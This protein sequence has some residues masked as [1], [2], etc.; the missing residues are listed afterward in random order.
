MEIYERKEESIFAKNVT[1]IKI[2]AH[3]IHDLCRLFPILEND[4]ISHKESKS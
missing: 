1:F 4:G 3:A 2:A